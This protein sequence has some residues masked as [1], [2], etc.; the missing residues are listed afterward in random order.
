MDSVLRLERETAAE[1]RDDRKYAFEER[2][3]VT[4]KVY[5]RAYATAYHQKLTG[6]VE[7]QMRLAVAL[8]GSFWY[9]CWV[10]AGQPNLRQLQALTQEQQKALEAERRQLQPVLVP[11]QPHDDH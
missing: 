9:T 4:V 11:V 10:D 3:G 2:A 1:I 6:Q 8:V 5:S 7:R